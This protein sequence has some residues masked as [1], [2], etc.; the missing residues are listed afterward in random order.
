MN[1]D[2]RPLFIG[3]TGS[4]GSGKSSVARIILAFHKNVELYSIGQKIKSIVFELDLSYRRDVL[5]DTGDFF[6]KHDPL[7]WVKYLSKQIKR[8]SKSLGAIIDDIRWKEEGEFFKAQ[9]FVLVRV[10]ADDALR[11]ERIQ[12]RDKSLVNDGDWERWNSHRTEEDARSMP[13]DY[14]IRN[15]G[16]MDELIIQTESLVNQIDQRRK[17]RNLQQYIEPHGQNKGDI[18]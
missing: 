12:A 13:V 5:Q 15:N 6:R 16:S 17:S 2:H 9:G 10:E 8:N 11:R 18:S 4:L 7:V 3:L 14:E 1:G